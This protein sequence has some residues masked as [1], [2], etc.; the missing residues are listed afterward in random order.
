MATIIAPHMY[1]EGIT[2]YVTTLGAETKKERK[3]GEYALR[4]DGGVVV[5]IAVTITY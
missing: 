4:L 1:S 5:D 2:G 3:R